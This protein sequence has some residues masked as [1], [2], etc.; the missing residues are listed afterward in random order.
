MGLRIAFHP[1]QSDAPIPTPRPPAT[2][3]HTHLHPHIHDAGFTEGSDVTFMAAAKESLDAI[4][5]WVT[6][7]DLLCSTALG[8]CPGV[9]PLPGR[10]SVQGGG[11]VVRIRLRTELH[12]ST[13]VP[14]CG[15]A[16]PEP[17]ERRRFVL[18]LPSIT[19]QS[20]ET[21][22]EPLTSITSSTYFTAVHVAPMHTHLTLKLMVAASG[23]HARDSF[24]QK[25]AHYA[26]C[27]PN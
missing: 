23:A 13:S 2:P 6:F 1:P 19:S 25:G 24:C 14:A 10:S 7:T 9:P 22:Q 15:K 18:S 26:L 16:T 21:S 17:T 11:G 12:S 20:Q 4:L 3:C 5:N 27:C 8:C